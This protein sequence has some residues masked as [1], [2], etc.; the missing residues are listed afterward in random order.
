MMILK[1][2]NRDFDIIY[3]IINNAA[4]AYRG[5]IPSDRWREPYMPKDE[6]Q[7]QLRQ[8]VEFYCYLDGKENSAIGVMGIQDKTNVNLIRHAYVKTT[9]RGEGIGSKLIQYLLENSTKPNLVGTWKAASWAI[10]FYQKHGFKLVNESTKN[11]LL[12]T[13]WDIPERQVD[14]SVVLADDQFDKFK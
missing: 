3:E 2:T 12:N 1:A 10:N 7:T 9:H 14:T 6:L 11:R 4:I 13:Y 8:G 5:K